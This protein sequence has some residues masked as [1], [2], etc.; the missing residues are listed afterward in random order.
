M[1]SKKKI[2]VFS[3]VIVIVL[4]AAILSFTM[5]RG[6]L[7]ANE[8]S[9][10]WANEFVNKEF[11]AMAKTK[12]TKYVAD[13]NVITISEITYGL[14]K[15]I[16][17]HGRVDTID[18]YKTLSEEYN[19]FLMAD[20]YKKG[21]TMLKSETNFLIEFSQRIEELLKQAEKKSLD[22]EIV[23]YETDAE[24]VVL[25][26]NNDIVNIV[27]GGLL[28]AA[29]EMTGKTTYVKI[30]ENGQEEIKE[31]G[32]P[33]VA[34]GF[35]KSVTP[36]FES[37]KPDT[38]GAIGRFINNF[39]Y[40]FDRNFIQH[41]RW[42]TI[43]KGL[44]ITIQLTFLAL[45]IG[46]VIGFLVA[47]VR[48]AYIKKTKKGWILRFFNAIC[49][50]YLTVI[51][52]TPAMVQIMVWHFVILQP[53][54]VPAS[55]SAFVCFGLNSGAYVAEI[56]RGGIMSVDAGQEEAGRSLGFNYSQTMVHIILPQAFKNVLPALANEFV[57][58]LKETSIAFYIGV[59]DLMYSL[60]TI[61]AATYSAFMPL[62]AAAIIY[63][64]MVLTFS[65]L[66]DILERRMRSSER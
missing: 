6:N 8:V 48:C 64:I 9:L 38:S 42:T 35:V 19:S 39:K 22:I 46:V 13:N 7:T 61:R 25:Y 15:D 10:E 57:V 54:G 40:D 30:G 26:A 62:I 28:D 11:D 52:G 33:N 66:V 31:I 21:T 29:S 27:Y 55:I 65:K 56:V 32:S 16:I 34:R 36:T 4:L 44:W 43:V 53:L 5:M 50:L 47:F 1:K 58:L 18:A 14:E 23:L 49:K 37:K 12:G 41:A 51:R 63:L 3:A 60:N 20:I 45:L 59:G 2:I 24:G 17:L